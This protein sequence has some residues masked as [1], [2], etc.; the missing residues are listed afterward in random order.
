MADGVVTGCI[1]VAA[2]GRDL[3]VEMD[4]EAK[5]GAIFQRIVMDHEIGRDRKRTRKLNDEFIQ[6]EA[7]GVDI[8]LSKRKEQRD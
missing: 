1:A 6:V 7:K 2:R 5:S 8:T 3:G 4:T